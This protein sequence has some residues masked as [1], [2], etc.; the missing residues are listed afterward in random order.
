MNPALHAPA[1]V[2]G[3]WDALKWCFGRDGENA[4]ARI[5]K[6]AGS[7][8]KLFEAVFEAMPQLYA[9]VV[10]L[11]LGLLDTTENAA[12]VYTS[13]ALSFVNI[14]VT[15]GS[16]VLH[17]L[18]AKTTT[19]EFVSVYACYAADA[20]SRTA[21]VALLFTL[22][23]TNRAI[24]LGVGGP[25]LLDLAVQIWQHDR[26]PRGTGATL[27][28]TATHGSCKAPSWARTCAVG[29]ATAATACLA[30]KSTKNVQLDGKETRL[31][32]HFTSPAAS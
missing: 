12:V 25:V 21:A 9:Q 14:S 22:G 1:P 19:L 7:N 27:S 16:K 6:Q 23:I 2:V 31:S 26:R 13:I 15:V 18:D 4:S 5:A 28:S 11:N 30:S 32:T 29:A 17:M 10:V 3:G 8:V 20:V 24:G